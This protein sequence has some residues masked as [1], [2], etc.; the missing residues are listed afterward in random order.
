MPFARLPA[1]HISS[2]PLPSSYKGGVDNDHYDHYRNSNARGS[3]YVE[4]V[5]RESN[6]EPQERVLN[7]GRGDS[8]NHYRRATVPLCRTL[9][10]RLLNPGTLEWVT[11]PPED[12]CVVVTVP[13][14]LDDRCDKGC[15]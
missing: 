6:E 7:E 5:G 11:G 4:E 3:V 8:V 13:L 10:K 9:V 1:R 15:G 2:A 14:M 12:V